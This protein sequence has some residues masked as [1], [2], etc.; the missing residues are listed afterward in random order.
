MN[1]KQRAHVH[2]RGDMRL[3]GGFTCQGCSAWHTVEWWK[4]RKDTLAEFTCNNEIELC[5]DRAVLF[6]CDTHDIVRLHDV[7]SVATNKLLAELREKGVHIHADFEGGG[8]HTRL[9][10]EDI[11]WRGDGIVIY[12]PNDGQVL[13]ME[14]GKHYILVAL[15][16][17][18]A[19][20]VPTQTA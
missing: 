19:S 12:G 3:R 4:G 1:D 18:G 11:D 14:P 15:P 6:L 20:D 13:G 8:T 2:E 16:A 5:G 9:R 17:E 7:A 10:Q